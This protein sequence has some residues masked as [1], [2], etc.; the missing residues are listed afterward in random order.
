ARSRTI[1]PSRSHQLLGHRLPRRHPL[2]LLRRPVPRSRAPVV[3]PPPPRHH[4]RRPQHLPP[5]APP[6]PRGRPLRL[7]RKTGAPHPPQAILTSEAN[8]VDSPARSF[9]NSSV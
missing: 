4:R 5:R 8:R 3:P 6:L 1:A 9:K 7:A 2:H